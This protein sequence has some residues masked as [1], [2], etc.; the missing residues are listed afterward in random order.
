MSLEIKMGSKNPSGVSTGVTTSVIHTGRMENSPVMEVTK[1]DGMEKLIGEKKVEL[2]M[3]TID[4]IKMADLFGQCV[5][6]LSNDRKVLI[7]GKEEIIKLV[8]EYNPNARLLSFNFNI[9][10]INTMFNLN[11]AELSD[12]LSGFF[13]ANVTKYSDILFNAIPESLPLM[14]VET[15]PGNKVLYQIH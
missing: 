15:L 3:I 5:K 9:K 4:S 1:V 11:N 6:D 8:S 10:E 7:N 12:F 2:K 13:Y 14:S